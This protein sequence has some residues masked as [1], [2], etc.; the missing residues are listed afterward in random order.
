[1][2]AQDLITQSAAYLS[3]NELGYEYEHWSQADLYGYY[4]LAVAL[5]AGVK[6]EYFTQQIEVPLVPGAMQTLPPP[7]ENVVDRR[8][9]SASG[10]RLRV[11]TG[12]LH[13]TVNLPTCSP[14]GVSAPSAVSFV[15]GNARAFVVDP[16]ATTG[17]EPVTVTCFAPPQIT[18]PDADVNI[19][20]TL[21]PAI[22]ELML[23]Y[24][25]GVDTESVPA[26]DRSAQHWNNAM[27]LL[28][29]ASSR[30][31]SA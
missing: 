26:R 21:R 7:C 4:R 15:P 23:Y 31:S 10:R 3:D 20:E 9:S 2:K 25:F 30:K 14:S 29:A 28:G 12:A 6:R 16:P 18:S 5:V 8:I 27:L 19:P 1:V 22:F 17:A 13:E 11:L 24:A